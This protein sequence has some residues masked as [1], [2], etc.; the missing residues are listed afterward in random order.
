MEINRRGPAGAPAIVLLHGIGS[1]WQV[2]EPILDRLA[3]AHDVVAV[4]LPGFGLSPAEPGLDLTVDGYATRV[5]QL[6]TELGLER[7]HVVGNSMGGGIAL[8]LGRRGVAGQV[9]AF[10]PVGFWTPL[11]RR[12]AQ[13]VITAMR[14]I[15]TVARPLVDLASRTRV[16]RIA[17]FSLFFGKPWLIEPEDAL[18]AV[19]GL[20]R[21]TAFPQARAGFN[22][23]DL[24]AAP[25][26]ADGLARIP[27]TIAW[28]SRDAILPARRQSAAA[29][30]LLPGA[31]HV[32]LP[33][34]GHLP[35]SDNPA[36]CASTVLG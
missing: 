28:G 14:A 8:E 2:F 32:P 5:A 31:R 29:R 26:P 21:A 15:S 25:R 36:L 24:R 18:L 22:A 30:K 17:L 4:D 9:T 16:G 13:G 10:S 12:W 20:I 35:F 27:V 6:I 3:G 7:P 1:R 33:G 11:E 19:D 23:Y 34:C